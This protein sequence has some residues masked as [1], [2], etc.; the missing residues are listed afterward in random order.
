MKCTTR[1]RSLIIANFGKTVHTFFS[2]TSTNLVLVCSGYKI[3]TQEQ[4]EYSVNSFSTIH[5]HTGV[6]DLSIYINLGINR[7]NCHV[8][9]GMFYLCLF[10]I[11]KAMKEPVL[12]SQYC[13]PKM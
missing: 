10:C 11:F 8:F 13:L 9:D 3:H 1:V 7:N 12:I 6:L 5:I 2:C 4:R